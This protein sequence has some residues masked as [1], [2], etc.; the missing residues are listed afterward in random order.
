[1]SEWVKCSERMPEANR[2][3]IIYQL[4][5][6]VLECFRTNLATYRPADFRNDWT[7][8]SG[9]DAHPTHWM[10]LPEPPKD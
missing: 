6:G 3:V 4:H 2:L 1:M 10:P 8:I 7:D 5:E 9:Y